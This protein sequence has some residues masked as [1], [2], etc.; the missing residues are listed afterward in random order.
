M[1]YATHVPST[2]SSAYGNLRGRA[3]SPETTTFSSLFL[4]A[5]SH[6]DH[7]HQD[8]SY[9]TAISW[10]DHVPA[11][12]VSSTQVTETLTRCS[13]GRSERPSPL[14]VG[15]RHAVSLQ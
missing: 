14:S 7:D 3:P 13:K 12:C 5:S 2:A 8:K 11:F 1:Y 15:T 9:L 4:I 10:T 6:F